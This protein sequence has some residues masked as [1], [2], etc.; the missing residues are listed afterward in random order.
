MEHAKWSMK[1]GG[2]VNQQP[3]YFH[4]QKLDKYAIFIN[5]FIKKNGVN[6]VY[7]P[8]CLGLTYIQL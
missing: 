5:S 7:A 1:H 2:E 6:W 3:N 8:I 4:L